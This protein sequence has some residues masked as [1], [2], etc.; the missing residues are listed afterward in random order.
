MGEQALK[1]GRGKRTQYLHTREIPQVGNKITIFRVTQKGNLEKQGMLYPVYPKGFYWMSNVPEKS[2]LFDDLPYFLN[3]LR[4]SGFLGRLIPRMYVDWS[5]PEDIRLWTAESTLRYLNNFG[6]DLVGDFIIGEVAARKFLQTTL[7]GS[8]D[9]NTSTEIDLYEDLAKEVE[10]HGIPGSSAGGEHPKFVTRRNAD[11][12]PV[13]VKFVAN[14]KSTVTQRRIDLLWAEHLATNL[15]STPELLASTRVIIG[16]AFTFLE[17]E[18]FDRTGDF[19][20][21]GI[22][23]LLSL[24]TEYVGSGESWETVAQKLMG[25]NIIDLSIVERT[26]FREYFGQCIGNTDMH[27]GNLSFFFEDEKVTG[28][29]P[30]YDMLPMKYAPVQERLSFDNVALTSPHPSAIAIWIRARDTAVLFWQ[31]VQQSNGI[32]KSFKEIAERN[33]AH[34]KESRI[35]L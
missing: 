11:G 16:E 19:G 1:V 13:L 15:L 10:R 33:E 20:R 29:T 4:P 22:I 23:S 28:I 12:V 24:D 32:S 30:I 6:L 8:S 7:Q 31:Q 21:R 26:Q 27:S 35:E 5:F 18:R 2:R 25:L 3:D 34:L 17:I 14:S 9:L